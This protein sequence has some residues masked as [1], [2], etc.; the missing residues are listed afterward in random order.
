MCFNPQYDRVKVK[1][2][3]NKN[4]RTTLGQQDD[5]SDSGDTSNNNNNG[6]G[7]IRDR[8][9]KDRINAMELN[10]SYKFSIVRKCKDSLEAFI[11]EGLHIKEER[12]KINNCIGNGF[13]H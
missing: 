5:P 9:E 4:K 10:K 13:I 2:V 7:P 6:R 12:P 8:L 11:S 3:R 1:T